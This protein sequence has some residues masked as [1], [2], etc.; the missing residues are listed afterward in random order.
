M[1]RDA[2]DARSPVA[3][4]HEGWAHLR[5]QRPLAAWA[6]WQQALRLAP[7]DRA[8]T[9]ALALLDSSEELPPIARVAH[10]FRSPSESNRR[11]LWSSAFAGRDLGD[12][13]AATEVFAE[14][15]TAVPRDSAAFYNLGLCAAW[16]GEN[17]SAI[18]ALNLSVAI[19]ATED[20]D[21]AV[22]SWMLAE[23][24]RQGAGAE[25][26]A[27][28]L[29]HFLVI[30]WP[31]DLGEPFARIAEFAALRGLPNPI[32]SQIAESIPSAIRI[33][34]WLN[35]PLSPV[36]V[37]SRVLATLIA[38]GDSVRL[39]SPDRGSLELAESILSAR[40]GEG[41]LP[42]DRGS[43]PLPIRLMDA[44]AW[45]M[46]LPRVVGEPDLGSESAAR[47]SAIEESYE[48][49]WI[50]GSRLGLSVDQRPRSPAE[51]ARDAAN[52]DAVA[53]VKLAAIVNLREQ[54][55]NRP[56]MAAMVDGYPF[57]RLRRRLGLPLRDEASVEATDLTSMCS[58]EL[59]RLDPLS[60]SDDDLIE[61]L[62]AAVSICDEVTLSRLSEAKAASGLVS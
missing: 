16:R 6:S 52:G 12:L 9:E 54:L 48:R 11:D 49:I 28:D 39:T 5:L 17:W 14:I 18:D 21:A 26:L 29:S 37:A 31:E 25:P 35:R 33:G 20:P 60:L 10:R 44:A 4:V 34:E 53:R 3:L 32:P 15:A 61:A 23:I 59:G 13:D 19:D 27:D 42:T 43:T 38:S 40:L 55:A 46:R 30:K 62:S 24:L 57:D 58:E 51:A 47:R 41:F 8:A 1:T 50:A 2:R 36:G 7:Q 56:R 22:A 45:L